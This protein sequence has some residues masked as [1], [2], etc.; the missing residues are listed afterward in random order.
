MTSP[1][2]SISPI[3]LEIQYYHLKSR[4]SKCVTS[5]SDD[6]QTGTKNSLF[7]EYHFLHF[8]LENKSKLKTSTLNLLPWF[9]ISCMKKPRGFILKRIHFFSDTF[10]RTI[11]CVLTNHFQFSIILMIFFHIWFQTDFM[12]VVLHLQKNMLI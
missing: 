5:F 12:S 6:P 9:D 1:N 7:S 8:T 11:P 2:F 4:P 10:E 3:F